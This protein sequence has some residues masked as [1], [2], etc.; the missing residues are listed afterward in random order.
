MRH[1]GG[2]KPVKINHSINADQSRSQSI[3]MTSP[4]PPDKSQDKPK[5]QMSAGIS[6]VLTSL[7]KP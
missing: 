6:R 4:E 5:S 3:P 7:N 2:K 1:Y